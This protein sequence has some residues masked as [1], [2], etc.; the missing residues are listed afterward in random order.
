[1][2][3]QTSASLCPSAPWNESRSTRDGVLILM[4][5]SLIG[6]ALR[7]QLWIGTALVQQVGMQT[8]AEYLGLSYYNT[9]CVQTLLIASG[10]GQRIA[11]AASDC[12]VLPCS[13]APHD[14]RSRTQPGTHCKGGEPGPGDLPPA[15]QGRTSTSCTRAL[16]SNFVSFLSAQAIKERAIRCCADLCCLPTIG[17]RAGFEE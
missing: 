5:R 11:Q 4:S 14:W 7:L 6:E 13:N 15:V 9:S 17:K 10:R 8:R 1:M 3:E 12:G 16:W 2:A